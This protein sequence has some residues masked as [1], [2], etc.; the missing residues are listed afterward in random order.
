M[1]IDTDELALR[2]KLRSMRG[3]LSEISRLSGVAL[4]IVSGMAS[5]TY[6]SSPSMRTAAKLKAA[7]QA[8]SRR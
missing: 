5:G 8:L 6:T 7:I 2:T 3:Q 1:N 4:R